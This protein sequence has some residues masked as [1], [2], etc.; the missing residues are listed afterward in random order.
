MNIRYGQSKGNDGNC[1]EFG[2]HILDDH[3]F[4]CNHILKYMDN[5]LSVYNPQV[6]FMSMTLSFY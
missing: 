4:I 5:V 1:R 3:F 6:K 2:R